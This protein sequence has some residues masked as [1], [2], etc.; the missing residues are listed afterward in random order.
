MPAQGNALGKSCKIAASPVR[1]AQLP[2][3]VAGRLFCPF[4]AMVIF[5]IDS[6]GGALG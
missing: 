6:Q 5:L 2:T 3:I 4:R 1:A